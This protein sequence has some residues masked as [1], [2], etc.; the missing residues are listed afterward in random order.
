[1]TNEELA[2]R[3]QNGENDLLP[4][5]WEQVRRFAAQQANR[6]VY[7][8]EGQ[9]GVEADDLIS[10]GFIALYAACE[11]YRPGEGKFLTW[12]SFYLKTAFAETCG[13]KTSKRDPLND[14]DSLDAPLTDDTD[15]TKGDMLA[16]PVDQ[17]ADA[18][19]KIWLEQ[20]QEA[21]GKAMDALPAEWRD[22]LHRYYWQGQ[23]LEEIGKATG[24]NKNNVWLR[25]GKGLRQLRRTMHRFGLDQ[26]VEE[27][28]PYYARVGVDSFMGTHTSAVEYAVIRRETLEQIYDRLGIAER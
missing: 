4:Q 9:Y 15:T 6:L 28:T 11:T 1:M 27:R 12:Y 10:A 7:K 25:H 18:E 19:H 16:D 2:Q 8:L 3:I 22:V 14:A 21:M 23:T 17:F 26:F 5:L 24:V 20:L 13:Y